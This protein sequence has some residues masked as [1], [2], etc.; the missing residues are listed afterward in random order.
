MLR[1]D[2]GQPPGGWPQALQAKALKGEGADYGTTG[3]LVEAGDFAAQRED[4]EKTCGRKLDDNEFSAYLMYPKVFAEFNIVNRKYGPVSVLPTSVFFTVMTTGDEVTLEIEQGKALV[5]LF[6]AL[7]ETRD[8]GQ[9]KF[10]LNST[11][12]RVSSL[13]Q[14]D[15]SCRQ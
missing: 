14:I 11:V 8:D 2:L 7:G 6:T 5:V 3:L 10:S 15:R 12:S 13:F 9:L 4:A 1:G